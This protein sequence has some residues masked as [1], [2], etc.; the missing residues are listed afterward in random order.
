MANPFDE[1][2]AAHEVAQSLGDFEVIRRVRKVEIYDR[3]LIPD[4]D[5]YWMYTLNYKHIQDM[6]E[7]GQEVP[8]ARLVESTEYVLRKRNASDSD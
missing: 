3:S 6:L 8:G 4:E 7:K 1:D 2:C 5:G